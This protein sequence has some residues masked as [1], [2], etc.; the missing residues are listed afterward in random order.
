MDTA[1]KA[2]KS[3]VDGT[4]DPWGEHVNTDYLD[5][6]LPTNTISSMDPYPPMAHRYSPVFPLSRSPSTR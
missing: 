1:N 2:A 3:F 5:M 6:Q 4:F